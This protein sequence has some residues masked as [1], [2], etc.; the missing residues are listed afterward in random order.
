MRFLQL[1][2]SPNAVI[3]KKLY[4]SGKNWVVASTLSIVGGALLFG[5]TNLTTVKASITD[6]SQQALVADSKTDD[7]GDPDNTD[8]T[9]KTQSQN[10]TNTD[11]QTQPQGSTSGSDTKNL[12]NSNS[13]VE[14]DSSDTKP[15]DTMTQ[16]VQTQRSVQ[17]PVASTAGQNEN[18]STPSQTASLV[19]PVTENA[20]AQAANITS[21][22]GILTISGG[23]LESDASGNSPLAAYKDTTTKVDFADKVTAGSSLKNLFNGFTNLTT[24][25]GLN[26]LDTSNVTNYS[27]MFNNCTSLT[28]IDISNFKT[29]VDSPT[30]LQ[31]MFANDAKLATIT[32]GG[33]TVP[34][35]S[36]IQD[37][38]VRCSA[39]T[40]VDLSGLNTTNVNNFSEMFMSCSSL[41]SLDLTH[42]NM[43]SAVPYLTSMGAHFMLN[44]TVGLESI[45]LNND[46]AIKGSSIGDAWVGTDT[47]G[48]ALGANG[49]IDESDSSRWLSSSDLEN[50][51]DGTNGT[52]TTWILNK[53]HMVT[54][55]IDLMYN[56]KNANDSQIDTSGSLVTGVEGKAVIITTNWGNQFKP[57]PGF[58]SVGD[59]LDDIHN[60]VIT[61]EYSAGKTPIV[62]VIVPAID[63][64][65]VDI[66]EEEENGKVIKTSEIESL[67]N[68]PNPSYTDTSDN[69][70]T[71]S[72]FEANR[73][74]NPDKTTITGLADLFGIDTDD[75]TYNEI[76]NISL[77]DLINSDVAKYNQLYVSSGATLQDLSEDIAGWI[78][79]AFPRTPDPTHLV[80]ITAVY[81]PETNTGGSGSGSG[82]GT[83]TNTDAGVVTSVD[84]TV[85]TFK[86]QPAAQLYDTDGNVLDGK[87][88]APDTGWKN[89]KKLVLD[90]V[91]Y[92][93]VGANQW[94][95]ADDVYI[96]AADK[97]YVRVYQSIDGI[98]LNAEGK[99]LNRAL[100]S[101]TDWKSDRTAII[102]G[103][104]YYRVATNEFV[105]ADQVYEYEYDETLVDTTQQT[106]LYDEHG[107]LLVDN[108]PTNGV[109]KTD[110]TVNIDG[111][112]YYRVATDE[113]VRADAVKI[114]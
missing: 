49:W 37:M 79:Y 20:S 33:F 45:T 7:S 53:K 101:G 89:D 31:Y 26:N 19:S 6:N 12:N 17:T 50:L 36:D 66:T 107:N 97:S 47:D 30:D 56:A 60:S 64:A 28:N 9:A 55:Q 82:S 72:N 88:L 94:V 42:T 76:N 85:S 102:N 40:G 61:P 109:Y 4:K 108:L 90:G 73:E 70:V 87:T 103:S 57:M 18:D 98:L 10:Q 93:R 95:K 35:V 43:R 5:A 69:K 16:G 68:A 81:K 51:Y 92:Y 11:T 112:E 114:Q 2:R 99:T 39:L 13:S 104:K 63:P 105:S 21:N 54:F 86:D 3:R 74:L 111:V 59:A 23:T 52:S 96:Y 71:M 78:G 8:D 44:G 14:N 75:P 46:D 58:V 113:F 34:N 65:Y 62:Q 106:N 83:D 25:T 80:S 100:K 41:S 48:A 91:T 15:A 38:F 22:N 24:I 32:M 84:Q 77:T 1:K 110:R 29:T 67:L 27:Y